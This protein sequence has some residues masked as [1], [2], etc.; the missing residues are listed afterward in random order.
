MIIDDVTREAVSLGYSLSRNGETV[1]GDKKVTLAKWA[2]GV[3]KAKASFSARFSESDK[4][5]YYSETVSESAIGVPPIQF[6]TRT[7]SQKGAERSE[8]LEAS[9]PHGSGAAS[10]GEMR[11]A[12]KQM[13]ANAGWEFKLKIL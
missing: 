10:Y 5:V 2:L 11:E 7:F 4:T 3:R 8:K 13:A 1:S 6:I 12:V 9:G